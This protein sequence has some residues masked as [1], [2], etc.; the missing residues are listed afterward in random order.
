MRQAWVEKMS[1]ESIHCPIFQSHGDEDPVLPFESAEEL[2]DLF[3]D[4]KWSVDW[5][6]F[7]GGHE[8]PRAVIKA[9]EK[10][11]NRLK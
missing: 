2:R 1:E 4:N 3:V 7:Q 9:C 5:Y 6:G 8:I 10:F 11:L